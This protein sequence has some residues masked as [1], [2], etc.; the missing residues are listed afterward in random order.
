M[1]REVEETDDIGLNFKVWWKIREDNQN[2]LQFVAKCFLDKK[3]FLRSFWNLRIIKS[4]LDI[5]TNEIVSLFPLFPEG[6]VSTM[7]SI[8]RFASLATVFN[9]S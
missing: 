3:K 6:D 8:G 5:F 1:K 7:K 2:D 9:S 4:R